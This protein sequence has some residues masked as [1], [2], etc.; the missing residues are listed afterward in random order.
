MYI[1][2]AVKNNRTTKNQA[3]YLYKWFNFPIYLQIFNALKKWVEGVLLW[4]VFSP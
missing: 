4:E 3:S 1:R 2:V